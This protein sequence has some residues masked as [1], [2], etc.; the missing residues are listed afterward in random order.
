MGFENLSDP[1]LARMLQAKLADHNIGP[2]YQ[3]AA[4]HRFAGAG[5]SEC[6]QSRVSTRIPLL[7]WEERLRWGH[8]AVNRFHLRD[9]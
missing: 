6:R 5:S 3:Y 2:A 4:S 9:G 8:S 1:M 7:L